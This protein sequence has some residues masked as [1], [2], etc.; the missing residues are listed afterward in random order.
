MAAVLTAALLVAAPAAHASSR[1]GAA[2][3]L[4]AD[5]TPLRLASVAL[6]QRDRDLVLTLRTHRR[7]DRTPLGTGAGH[8]CL[9]IT[10]AHDH[11]VCVDRRTGAWRL[12]A[13]GRLVA[14]H[15]SSPRGGTLV[16]RV[17][18]GDLGLKAGAV[19]WHVA[20]SPDSCGTR[21]DPAPDTRGG[22][23]GTSGG[24]PGTGGSPAADSAGARSAAASSCSSRAPRAAGATYAGRVWRVVLRGCTPSGPAEVRQ[25]PRTKQVA[26]TYDDGPASIT[27]R[28]LATLRRLAV[29]ATFFMLGQQVAA[30]PAITRQVLA[31]GHEIGDHSWNHANLGGGGP[32]ASAQIEH[33]NAVI[34]RV[35]GFT[36][37]LF[38]PPGGSTGADLVSR[39]RALGMTSVLWSADPFDWRTP[40]TTA[41]VQRVLAEAGPGGILLD[42]D[43]G[44]PR[45]QTLAAAPLIVAALRA[46]GYTFVTVSTLL[47]YRERLALVR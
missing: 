40:G 14:G 2:H 5:A 25:G 20:A 38:R 29:P 26:L 31:D 11:V 30:N 44:G 23:P 18:P 17:R 37:C 6:G 36:P 41:I 47:G 13:A 4:A 12:K 10:Q 22:E 1:G 3:Q 43:G 34:R 9:T 45:Q 16:V 15:V 33:T 46:R 21:P 27:P 19:R 28:F 24:E 42:H 39:V 7:V 35:T 8:V 32:A